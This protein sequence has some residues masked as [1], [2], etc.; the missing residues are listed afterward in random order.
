MS[1]YLD[2]VVKASASS[3]KE[4]KKIPKGYHR[5][6]DGTIMKDSG[7][8]NDAAVDSDLEDESEPLIPE[9][10][11]LADA[12]LEI[13]EKHG[14]FNADNTGVWA[15]YDSAEKNAD[16]AAIGVKCGN[17]VFWEGPNGCKITVNKTEEGGL[18]RF[19]ILPDYTITAAAGS[20]RAPKKDRVKGSSKNAKGS[21]S[22]SG[23]VNFSDK[24]VKALQNKADE[25]NEKHGDTAS[26][27][28]SV[29]TLKAVYRRG[30]GAF[31]TGYRPGQNRNS[32]AMARVNA[33]LVILRTGNPTNSKYTTDNDL[34][35]AA[36][37][38]STKKDSAITA[39]VN[40]CWEGYIQIGMKNKDGKEVPNCVPKDA[41][42]IDLEAVLFALEKS[43]SA[44]DISPYLITYAINELEGF[45]E[46]RA[47]TYS[48]IDTILASCSTAGEAV[49]AVVSFIEL[50]HNNDV[51]EDALTYAHLLPEGHPRS[52]VRG[53]TA[54]ARNQAR[55]EWYCADM[56]LSEITKKAIVDTYASKG[57]TVEKKFALMKI[58]ALTASGELTSV[59]AA[60]FRMTRAKRSAMSKALAAVR[61]R[62]RGGKFADEY[63]RLK[64]FF[65]GKNGKFTAVGRMVGT[66]AGKNEFQVEYKGSKNIPD[67]IY[68]LPADK[69][70]SVGAYL[71]ERITS[72]LPK[73]DPVFDEKDDRSLVDLDDFLSTKIDSPDGWTAIKNEQGKTTG[74]Q[75]ADGN[76]ILSI[77]A[78]NAEKAQSI[79]DN[80]VPTFGIGENEAF[81]LDGEIFTL[82]DADGNVLAYAQD[83]A[84]AQK[85]TIYTDLSNDSGDTAPDATEAKATKNT[86]GD[87]VEYGKYSEDVIAEGYQFDK[88]SDGRWSSEGLFD[89]KTEASWTV[90][91]GANSQEG[92]WFV[93]AENREGGVLDSEKFDKPEDAFEYAANGTGTRWD[94]SWVDEAVAD[95]ISDLADEYG[96]DKLDDRTYIVNGMADDKFEVYELPDGRWEVEVTY[97][98]GNSSTETFDKVEDAF[99]AV[100]AEAGNPVENAPEEVDVP[101][102]QVDAPEDYTADELALGYAFSKNSDGTYEAPDTTSDGATI[103]VTDSNGNWVVK[104]LG[105]NGPDNFDEVDLADFDN[106]ADA[107]DF[108]NDQ[109]SKPNMFDDETAKSEG[110]EGASTSEVEQ[111]AADLDADDSKYL[112]SGD[113]LNT[114]LDEFNSTTSSN[115]AAESAAAIHTM[116]DMIKDPEL[117]DRVRKLAND[118]DNQLRDKF[119]VAAAAKVISEDSIFDADGATDALNTEREMFF[120]VNANTIADLVDS[121]DRYG[122]SRSGGAQV[123]IGEVDGKWVATVEY[124]RDSEEF[125]SDDRDEA[126]A[127]AASA[128]AD[129]NSDVRPGAYMEEFDLQA[130]IDN[131]K[132]DADAEALATRLE[133]VADALDDNR[134]DLSVS[135]GLREYGERIRNMLDN[136]D[137]VQDADPKFFRMMAEE[138]PLSSS[139]NP[140]VDA[141]EVDAPV[142][143]GSADEKKSIVSN[144]AALDKVVAQILGAIESG[145]SMPWRK[146]FADDPTFAGAALP[147][148]PV[149]KHIYSG[150]N[151]MVLRW[152]AADKDYS[153]GR[154]VTYNGAKELG[155]NIRLGEKGT[156]ILAPRMFA[157]KDKDGKPLFD[158]AGKPQQ[159]VV[160]RAVAV[161]NVAQVDGISLPDERKNESIIEAKTP[162][163][164]QDFVIGRYMKSMEELGLEVP[165]IYYTYVGEYGSHNS[166]PNWSPSMDKITLPTKEQFNS[167]EEMFDTLMHE[168]AHSTG[169]ASRLDR[170]DLTKDYG[171]SD[172]VAR[173]KEELI[174][175]ISSAILGQMFGIENT[176]DNS[177]AYV[178]SWLKRLKNNPE[179]VI[180]ASKEAQKVVDY[181]LGMH[182][183]DWSPVEGYSVKKRT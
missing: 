177:A 173:A 172:G 170:T 42:E 155:G 105:G 122:D 15:G 126:I 119:G 44:E 53:L 90:S 16:N 160:F 165:E 59:I 100:A 56:S 64:G 176:L 154:W 116:A 69:A 128:A 63:G 98:D 84:T 26:K 182:I 161:F 79:I 82:K 178:Q 78:P 22:S 25:H 179:E 157:K 96:L 50:A 151:S 117:S 2:D 3:D 54:S 33:F 23:T 13:V 27:K 9:E 109:I 125:T 40:P 135:R 18:C 10:Q 77:E 159:F 111:L 142:G 102:I 62:D 134:G 147:R 87:G 114:Y 48:Q 4:E 83:W 115:N 175:E 70:E 101:D 92:D 19:A 68:R 107:F 81:E 152:T 93:E 60:G 145:D 65:G 8:D 162:L 29:R 104:E 5:M 89:E 131:A 141:S 129:Y 156:F 24:V 120:E 61:R 28:T 136:G 66:T 12:L 75:S 166:S 153:D 85:A 150:I 47:V 124:D 127:Q 97:D 34:L 121:N 51:Y 139:I 123:N 41:A 180:Y 169:H 20:K 71:P 37:K 148:N 67:G 1:E 146:P 17:C 181:M 132:T 167:P 112:Y 14:K 133:E 72:K 168:M 95:E 38:R 46:P 163:E 49:V 171:N 74:Y 31:S 39:S 58:D 110:D 99:K 118:L 52:E 106:P 183:G 113:E 140:S 21:A 36:H 149:S 7:H 80:D 11:D 130:E 94:Q 73:V 108:A 45:D 86:N 35:P 103:K 91:R 143:E 6:P 174:A 30:A 55:A 57:E 158:S 144:T 32:W 76:R 164:A 138:S 88:V 137:L 43:E